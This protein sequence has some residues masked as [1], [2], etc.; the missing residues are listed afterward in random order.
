MGRFSHNIAINKT[1][2]AQIKLTVFPLK[3]LQRGWRKTFIQRNFPRFASD[4]YKATELS[5]FVASLM[6]I[7]TTNF[8]YYYYY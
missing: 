5:Y 3:H 4:W 2:S 6:W 8:N 7:N 1:H